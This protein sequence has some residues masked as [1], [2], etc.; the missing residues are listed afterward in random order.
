[1]HY[2]KENSYLLVNGTKIHIFKAKEYEIKDGK[3]E[4]CLENIS[5]DFSDNNMKKTR[6]Y[7]NVHDFSVDF[8]SIAV[9]DI[10]DIHKHLMEKNSI[11]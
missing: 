11:K 8:T 2:N 10:L 1:M 3:T 4:M 6:L 9:N 7:G 5:T